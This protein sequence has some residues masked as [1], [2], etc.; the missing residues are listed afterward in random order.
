LR[1][2]FLNSVR[3][4]YYGKINPGLI[5]ARRLTLLLGSDQAPD[6]YQTQHPHGAEKS[7]ALKFAGR[8]PKYRFGSA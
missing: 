7:A 5:G 1:R 8:L 4:H 6:Q 2:N 3:I